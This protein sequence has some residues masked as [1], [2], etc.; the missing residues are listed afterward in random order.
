[1]NEISLI[2][3]RKVDM[4]AV[5]FGKDY[6]FFLNAEDITNQIRRA[7]KAKFPGFDIEVDNERIY[8]E[9]Y[10]RQHGTLPPEVGSDSIWWNFKE[11]ILTDPLDAPLEALDAGVNKLFASSGIKIIA[12][13]LVAG[14]IFYLVVVYGKKPSVA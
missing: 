3:G 5:T 12:G 8:V 4:D 14:A 6:H 2:D 11:Q 9:K 1:M 10:V 7:D 13:V